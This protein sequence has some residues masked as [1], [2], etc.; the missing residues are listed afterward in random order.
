MG[1]IDSVRKL[2][3]PPFSPTW[4]T[5]DDADPSGE[6]EVEIEIDE[7]HDLA[8][9]RGALPPKAK[10]PASIK[11]RHHKWKW[12]GNLGKRSGG[13]SGVVLHHSC[14]RGGPETIHRAHLANGW[15]GIAYHYYVRTNGE[16]HEGR[17]EWAIGGHAV[18][19]GAWLGICAE[20]N[21]DKTRKMPPAQLAAL[22]GL[23]RHIRRRH[24]AGIKVK[25]HREMPK[26]ST[27]CPGRFYPAKEVRGR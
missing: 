20:G 9:A 15:R 4:L 17:P 21:Y 1:I 11:I 23:M 10:K 3:E 6:I 22:K 13:P 12:N 5:A 26:N 19:A 24:G 18:G 7:T 27:A 2:L 8:M 16:I 25:L 14:G